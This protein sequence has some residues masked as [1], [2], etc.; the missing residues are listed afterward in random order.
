MKKARWFAQARQGVNALLLIALMMPLL[1]A[2]VQ[3]D[4]ARFQPHHAHIYLGEVNLDHHGS[5]H[6]HATAV[7]FPHRHLPTHFHPPNMVVNVPD[8][9][10]L[11][12]FYL[13]LPVTTLLL[14][15]LYATLGMRLEET[16]WLVQS[17]SPAPPTEPPRFPS[18]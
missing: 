3:V 8:F 11:A 12:S 9:A 6:A 1:A 15:A 17:I 7:P 2:W 14:I 13:L 18:I 16:V 10:A 5:E 4:L